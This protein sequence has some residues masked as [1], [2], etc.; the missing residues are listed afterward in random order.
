[1]FGLIH[2]PPHAG[3]LPAAATTLVEAR[4]LTVRRGDQPVLCNVDLVVESGQV[5]TLVGPNGS[6]KSTLVQVLTG[7]IRDYRGQVGRRTGL[8]VGYVPQHFRIDRN[9]PI[10]VR[11]FMKLAP[12]GRR[13][14]WAEAVADAGVSQLLDRPMQG[15]SGGELRRV[16]LAR[17]LLSRPHLLAL[18]EP[19]AGLDQRGQGELYRLIRHVRDRYG[20]G[21]L[22]VSHDLN[23]VMA[24]T[25]QV[26]CL[27]EGHI[28]CRGAPESVRAHPEYRALFGA[29]LG[30]E[31]AVFPHAH[32][33][34]EGCTHG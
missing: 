28:L 4:G 5:V 32:G 7:V 8:R 2:N 30:P 24:A 33:P 31:T 20:C 27:S 9:L 26:L 23:L 12:R 11:R 22:V 29:H 10:T 13:G 15:L 14:H 6:G 16:L 1:M 21:V 19:A 3:R 25:D 18:D 34:G 17:A